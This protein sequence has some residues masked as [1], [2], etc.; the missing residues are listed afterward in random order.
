MLEEFCV[1]NR[2]VMLQLLLTR[3]VP[4]LCVR[5]QTHTSV[6]IILC[7]SPR[8]RALIML[9]HL[10]DQPGRDGGVAHIPPA[11]VPTP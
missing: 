8:T 5:A 9:I 6:H 3:R 7:A 1:Q 4:L 10:A 2:R 11:P